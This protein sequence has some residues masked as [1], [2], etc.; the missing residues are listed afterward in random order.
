MRQMRIAGA[1][2]VAM[3]AL[4]SCTL[5]GQQ[6]KPTITKDQAD[7]QL[8]SYDGQ[9]LNALLGKP[10]PSTAPPLIGECETSDITGPKGRLQ[11]SH[12]T[13]VAEN[14]PEANPA[15]FEAFAIEMTSLGFQ[16]YT[17]EADFRVYENKA[18]GFTAN[19]KASSDGSKL[20]LSVAS[21]CVWPNGTAGPEQPFTE[22]PTATSSKPA[23]AG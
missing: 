6:L 3:V 4:S 13:V 17:D 5:S 22:V 10:Q 19:L 16:L 21:P 12:D 11:L 20:T 14:H 23:W 18:N 8:A 1:V 9:I 7:R 15:V 2:A